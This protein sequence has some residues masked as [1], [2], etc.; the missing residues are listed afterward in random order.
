MILTS[1]L[2]NDPKDCLIYFKKRLQVLHVW[3]STKAGGEEE[4]QK[5]Q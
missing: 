3:V 5:E 1:S 4:K 2:V